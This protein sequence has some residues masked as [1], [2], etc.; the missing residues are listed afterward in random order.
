MKLM[1]GLEHYD[2]HA[3]GKRA[4]YNAVRAAQLPEIGFFTAD[5]I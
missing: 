3:H 4:A 5:L 1:N 2:D